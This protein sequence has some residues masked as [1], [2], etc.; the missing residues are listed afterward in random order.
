MTRCIQ[1]LDQLNDW[2][3]DYRAVGQAFDLEKHVIKQIA[4][5]SKSIKES[6]TDNIIKKLCKQHTRKMTIVMLQKLICRL[7]LVG[8]EEALK[9]IDEVL[10]TYS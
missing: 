10:E 8:N 7:S 6:T 9:T 5:E 3:E 4:E 2:G 1:R